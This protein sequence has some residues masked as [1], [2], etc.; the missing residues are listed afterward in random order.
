MFKTLIILLSIQIVYSIKC[1]ETN[2]KLPLEKGNIRQCRR[3]QQS[4]MTVALIYKVSPNV[5]FNRL[6]SIVS[7]YASGTSIAE[8]Q[9]VTCLALS[10]EV[11]TV[12]HCAIGFC[13]SDLCNN[14]SFVT[15]KPIVNYKKARKA[16]FKNNVT[17]ASNIK[18]FWI[19]NVILLLVVFNVIK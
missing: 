16:P 10:K 18:T 8:F 9:Q 5:Y 17:L 19:S 14:H 12:T 4:C 3:N 11:S 2:L 13:Y 15:P 6:C 7:K 1:Y